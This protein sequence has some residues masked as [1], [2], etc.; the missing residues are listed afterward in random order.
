MSAP[1]PPRP[2]TPACPHC[3]HWR[4]RRG[5]GECRCP[6]GPSW[7]TRRGG[8]FCLSF[9]KRKGEI[10]WLSYMH[11]VDGIDPRIGGAR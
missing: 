4:E 3:K 2:P 10:D 7:E 8:R 6:G 11:D 1:E 5:S 9:D